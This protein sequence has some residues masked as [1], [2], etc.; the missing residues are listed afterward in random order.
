MGVGA[1]LGNSGSGMLTGFAAG[2][3]AG[4]IYVFFMNI[5]AFTR[6]WLAGWLIENIDPSAVNLPTKQIVALVF[7][8]FISL[9]PRHIR[10]KKTV[11][12]QQ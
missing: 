9:Y 11:I 7:L 5:L 2:S 12:Q 3:I 6:I 4:L 10:R 8:I 1:S